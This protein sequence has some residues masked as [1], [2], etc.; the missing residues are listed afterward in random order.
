MSHPRASYLQ[1]FTA[2]DYYEAA[3]AFRGSLPAGFM[4]TILYRN[5]NPTGEIPGTEEQWLCGNWQATADDAGRGWRLTVAQEI[6][7]AMQLSVGW[8]DA[9]GAINTEIIAIEEENVT[10]QRSILLH[11]FF[12]LQA[13]GEVNLYLW[14]N[15]NLLIDG[16]DELAG[17]FTPAD[18]VNPFTIGRGLTNEGGNGQVVFAGTRQQVAGF[19]FFDGVFNTADDVAIGQMED[20]VSAHWNL[21]QEAEGDVVPDAGALITDILSVRRALKN[22]TPTWPSSL[23]NV[24]LDRVGVASLATQAANPRFLVTEWDAP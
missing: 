20:F 5:A 23:G 14:G 3:G 7:T 8:F 22:P 2:N 1:G 10:A 18:A 13:D 6:A 24:A 4:A 19:G 12:G 21:V 15:G 11:L 16:S 9:G 17:G